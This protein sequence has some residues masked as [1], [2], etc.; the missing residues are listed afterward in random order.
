MLAKSSGF[1]PGAMLR[2]CVSCDIIV[3]AAQIISSTHSRRDTCLCGRDIFQNVLFMTKS[4]TLTVRIF[5]LLQ[6]SN[7][8]HTVSYIV[9]LNQQMITS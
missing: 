9:Q 1:T 2:Q 4:N 8:L 5:L 3:L 7:V 6:V